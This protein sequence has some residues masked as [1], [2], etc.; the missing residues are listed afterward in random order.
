[1]HTHADLQAHTRA[2]Y[3]AILI[4][5]DL[6][7][8]HRLEASP[9]AYSG[10]LQSHRQHWTREPRQPVGRCIEHL[11]SHVLAVVRR[12]LGTPHEGPHRGQGPGAAS[13]TPH[14]G[15]GPGASSETP[16]RGQGPGAAGETPHR[17]QGPGAA[18]ETPHGAPPNYAPISRHDARR[19]LSTRAGAR[20]QG[21]GAQQAIGPAH[22]LLQDEESALLQEPLSRRGRGSRGSRDQGPGASRG[23]LGAGGAGRAGDACDEL[24]VALQHVQQQLRQALRKVLSET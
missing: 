9:S 20:G 11:I 18:R 8:L 12:T 4:S 7:F 13:E 15:Q 5:P 16:H 14:R 2:S 21:P 1:M 6:S 24:S 3:R 19:F 17:G 10:F 22:A 23:S